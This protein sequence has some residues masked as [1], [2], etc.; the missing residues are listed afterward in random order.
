MQLLHRFTCDISGIEPPERFNNPFYYSPHR[1]CTIATDEVRALLSRDAALSCEVAKGKM[2]GVLVV[3]DA[4]GT[5]GYLAAFSGLLAGS[6]MV[7]GFVPPVYDL[8]APEGYFK[9]E[10]GNIS[11]LNI[12]IDDIK[13]SQSYCNAASELKRAKEDA[14]AAIEALVAEYAANKEARHCRRSAGELTPAEEHA[15]T[16]QSQFEKA[17]LKRQR[18]AWQ[19]IIAE[20]E[21]HLAAF[22]DKIAL[23]SNER[24][25]RSLALQRW[26]FQ[27][28]KVMNAH[29]CEKS[30]LDI[31]Q[32]KL[33]TMPPA[34]AGE[35]AAPKL[36]QYAFMNAHEPL[37]M[38]E[39][40]V[41]DSPAGEVRRDGCYYGSC[42][43]KC[44]P[45]LGY[46]LQ[47]VDVEESAL[48]KGAAI[49]SVEVLFEDEW[50]LAVN[51]PSGVLSVPGVVGGVS[52]QQW[53]R[54]HYLRSN[55]LYVVHRLDMATS[56]VLL[57][58]K[59]IEVYKQLQRQFAAREVK[60][61]YTALL[62]GVPQTP[63]GVITLPLAADYANRPRQKVDHAAGKEAITRYRVL[64]SVERDG[65]Q[66]AV[67][68]FEP[69]T[70]RT[71]Q[72]RVHA[73]HKD[74]LNTPIVGDALYGTAA[75]RLMLHASSL[76]FKHP[77]LDVWVT[78]EKEFFEVDG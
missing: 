26:L 39:F 24:K 41:G 47:G 78:V 4:A 53:L 1:L 62:S 48:E 68:Q 72:L 43:S 5:L 28:F 25:N 14:S 8:L 65:K 15:M 22:N 32:Q 38:A 51:K 35:C 66:C 36:L 31:F 57:A 18:K 73:A 46:M 9:H 50:L 20:K 7:A 19:Q 55:E 52:L 34:G 40:W 63:Q 70:G 74:G 21:A 12:A 27:Q 33:G 42:K 75:G 58:A 3:R 45:I 10:E 59:S 2:F 44:E 64:K 11:A 37:C 60:K 23:L 76:G 54:E 16:R 61:N 13:R 69:L 67:V 30:L 17:E 71:H 56:G 6:N 49:D 77:V 29:G